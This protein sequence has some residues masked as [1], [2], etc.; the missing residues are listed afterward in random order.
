MKNKQLLAF[1]ILVF[2]LFNCSQ[3]N[4]PSDNSSE[5]F[6]GFV[7][8]PAEA[9]P[10][11]RWWWNGDKITADELK[12]ELD[13][14][15]AAGIGGIEINPIAM[16]DGAVDIGVKSVEW[17]SKDWNQLLAFSS[18]E[19]QKRKMIV[20]MIVGSGWP[21]GGEFLKKDETLQR[22]IINKIPCS[23]GSKIIESKESL[24]KK[25]LDVQVRKSE[26]EAL[27]NEIF[28]AS[29]IPHESS[30]LSTVVD[31]IDKFSG[32]IL[33][34]DV[35]EGDYQ[36]VYGIRQTGHREVMYGAPGAAGPVMDHYDS[37]VTKEYLNRLMKI[38][39]DTG[40]PLNQLVRALFCDSI[41]LAGANWTDGFADI[42]FS[43]YNYRLEPYY[44]FI[45]YDGY[46]GYKSEDYLPELSDKLKRVRYD[47][48][49]LLIR[50]FLDNFTKVFQEFCTENGVKCRYQA[51][52]T[53][54]LMGIMEGNMIV[55]IPE[56]NNWI[57]SADMNAEE[58]TWNP[59][60]GYM[61]WNLYA[62]SGGHLKGRKI[63]SI[64][65]MTNT[66]G[67]FST[68]LD[69][70]KRTDDMNFITGM[71]HTILHGFNYSPP[72]AGFPGW[73][74]Y[75]TY[76]SEQN[77]WWPYFS[78]W[79]DYNARLSYV[80]QQSKPIKDIAI[81]AP[82]GD[83]WSKNGLTRTPFHTKP[84]YC[85]RL[86]EPLSQAG[87]SCD[88]I[89]EEIIREGKKENGKLKF[90]PMSYQTI[91]LASVESLEPETALALKEFVN[92]GGQLVMIDEVP[93]RSLSLQN[94]AQNDSIV[95]RIF[96]EMQQDH[97]DRIVKLQ[98]PASK[99]DML[100]WTMGVLQ[101]MK[102][103]TDVKIEAPDKN[104]FQIKTTEGEKDIYFF[105]NTNL[106]KKAT[107]NTVFP[108]G[109]KT[110][111]VWNPEDG[112]RKVF[113][114]EKNKNE[115]LIT[116]QPLQSLLLVFDTELKG[117]PDLSLKKEIGSK[118]LTIEGPWLLK[119][120]HMNGTSFERK[121]EKLT[122]FTPTDDNQLNTF[123]GTVTYS[124][125]FNSNGT[126]DWLKFDKANKGVTEVYINGKLAGV[127]WYGELL[128]PLDS[129]LVKGENK[130]EIKYTTVLRNYCS[131]LKDN[132]MAARWINEAAPKGPI[133]ERWVADYPLI[134][135]GIEGDA[136]IYNK[137][138]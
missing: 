20:D 88:Y 26:G 46:A 135:M 60:H 127:K 114:Y 15:H 108:T 52:G 24:L 96:A 35:P 57:Y 104:I 42:F 111:W 116:L 83:L 115:L 1:A 22:I 8:P 32:D 71:N 21:F 109:K 97:S 31:V 69:E 61:V 45:F 41:E 47:Y 62:S 81:L 23:G 11:V 84:W 112:T 74:R 39:E 51:Y 102:I 76:F 28:F 75:G 101:K 27:G 133:S 30:S 87:S 67:V 138:D 56:S 63:I 122:K 123:A 37:E 9:R 14:M 136:I 94:A 73:V 54:F 92:K 118:V 79:A 25:A 50:T 120:N 89:S 49:K 77:P 19:A 113:P 86:W 103:D 59:V 10:F 80:F 44:P 98:S 82:A 126:G 4:H 70:I 13:I 130:L 132:P 64:E 2:S 125:T 95:Q 33:S 17:L 90:G 16:P 121:F 34:F 129:L 3:I 18:Q 110:P 40:I 66:N 107:I 29:L 65:A 117:E 105:T 38:S 134:P 137:K 36:F 99:S 43:A 5:L 7:N 119:F 58:W 85:Y 91:F 72:E 128:Y 6:K 131:S 124:T 93:H 12:R 53:P 48:N 106:T 68:S 55:D 100:S 78:K